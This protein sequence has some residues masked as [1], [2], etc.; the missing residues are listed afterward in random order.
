MKKLLF[1]LSVSAC[2]FSCKTENKV[3]HV[4]RA[5]YYWKNDSSLNYQDAERVNRLNVNKLYVKYFEIDY[6]DAMGNFPF[7]KN[8]NINYE[9]NNIQDLTI[10]PT[11]Y[12]KNEIFKFNTEKTL[13]VLADNIVFLVDKYNKE[14]DEKVITNKEI[15]IDCDWTAS[16]KDKYFYLLKKIKEISKREISCTLRLYPYKYPDKMGVPPV[17]KVTLMCYNLIKPLSEKEKNSILDYD[18]LKLYLDKERTYPIHTDI[19]LPIFFWSHLYQANQFT[20]VL[21]LNSKQVQVFAKPLRPLWYEVTKD[22][23]IDYDTYLRKG[24]KI[25]CEE[26]S[27]ETLNKTIALIKKN[28]ALD[29]TTTISLF[30][31][32]N[33][34]LN[35][36]SNEEISAFFD[37]F[38]K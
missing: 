9:V 7:A 29:A 20:E 1:L 18:E 11:I 24:D 10:I 14:I 2:F 32:D 21:K 38:S 15:Q 34:V 4:E 35:Q 30:H 37:S 8:N 6:N 28:V 33:D 36:Y 3:E 25:K 17:D 31:I 13:D 19:A 5:F 16:T 23:V 27:V 12:V 26:V 22:T